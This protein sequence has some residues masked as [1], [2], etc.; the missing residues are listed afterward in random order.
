MLILNLNKLL[1]TF[2][3]IQPLYR[4]DPSLT[5]LW[6]STDIGCLTVSGE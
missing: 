1:F 6:Y 2:A 4:Q 5:S 3:G